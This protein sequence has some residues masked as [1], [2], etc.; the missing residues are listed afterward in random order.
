PDPPP[1]RG[2]RLRCLRRND[3]EQLL[4]VVCRRKPLTEAS[5]RLPPAG[6]PGLEL[7]EPRLELRRHVVERGTEGRELVVA[8]DGHPLGQAPVRD[9]PRGR[10]ETA[11]VPD[12]RPPLQV[13][14]PTYEREACEQPAEE[15]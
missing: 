3:A 8:A 14:D 7:G 15:P 6:A 13:R 9:L 10:G 12:D 5:Q 1:S 2:S 11:E 4:G